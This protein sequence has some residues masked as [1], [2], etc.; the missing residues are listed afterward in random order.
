MRAPVTPAV[1]DLLLIGGGHTHALALRMLAMRPLPGVRVTLVSDVSYAPYSGMLPGHVA[2]FYSWE[3]MHI[4]LRRLAAF[5]GAAFVLGQ[6]DG[7][8]ADQRTVHVAGR[9]PM[10]ASVISLNVGSTPSLSGVPGAERW[11][12]PA[13]PVPELLAGWDRVK[14]AAADREMRIVLVGGGAGGVELALTMSHVLGRRAS[15][16][17]LHQGARL[18]PGH[19]ERVRSILSRLLPER[20]ITVRTSTQVAEVTA[21]GVRTAAGDFVPADFVFWVTHAAAPSW[22]AGSSLA[23]TPEGFIRVTPKLQAVDHPWIFAVGDVATLE[24]TPRPKSGVFAVRMA[25][26]LVANLR[27]SFSG[28]PLKSYHPQRQFLSLIGTGDGQAVASRRWLAGRS[29]LFWAL[30]DRIDRR[31]MRKFEDLPVMADVPEAEPEDHSDNLQESARM[32]C[33]GCAA[34]VAST[35]LTRV[36]VR[37]REEHGTAWQEAAKAGTVM[38]GLDAPDDAAVFTVPPG[39]ALVQTVD[40]MPALVPDPYLFGR[41]AT[42]HSLSDLFAMGADPHSVLAAALVPFA[43]EPVTEE[44]L[45]QLLSG[46]LRELTAAEAVL[47]GGHTA[48][49]AVT[50]LALT[51]NGLV[52]LSGPSHLLR[53]SG[54]RAGDAL[55]LT[56]P[57]GIGVLF[58]S[59]MRLQAKAAWIDAALD[60]MLLSN[61]TAATILRDH[62]ATACTDVTGFGLAGHLL[63]MLQPAG[64]GAEINLA[65]LPALPGAL[66][67]LR[68]GFTSSLAPANRRALSAI[69]GAESFLADERLALLFDP[70]T[71]GGLLAG[72]PAERAVECLEALRAVGYGQA[73]RIGRAGGPGV[74]ISLR[75][76]G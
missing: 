6:V 24:A 28:R 21:E 29:A 49:G 72:V 35:T 33:L 63:E 26:P 42:L 43:S 74:G 36:M 1:Q 31:F 39:R 56:K 58:A 61:R 70:Q 19:N 69:S 51:C 52:D 23:T 4:D 45:Y 10:R 54:L 59:H 30:K 3:E 48:E 13:K 11:V 7:L 55:L 22:I 71:S 20:G 65:A 41:I 32:R 73:V 25:K 34:K 5:A 76:P 16:T 18:L 68:R 17:L 40:Y 44:T 53:K 38:V 66:D 14:A 46:V 60:S 57:L 37:L 27:A 50:G 75:S 12:I 8:D 64:L 9:P 67:C 2:G 15:I 62:G 47:I